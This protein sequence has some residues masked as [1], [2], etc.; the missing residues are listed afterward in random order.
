VLLLHVLP[1]KARAGD[2]AQSAEAA[3]LAYLDTVVAYFHAAGISA[4]S[5]VRY[6]PAPATIVREAR[7]HSADLI[8]LG[9]PVRSALLRAVLGSVADTVIRTAPCPVLLVQPS[10]EAGTGTPLRSFAQSAARAGALTRHPPRRQTVEV[11]RIIG[12]VGRVHELGADFRPPRRVRR[13]SDDQRLARVRSAM[14]RGQALPPVELYQL[15]F[16]Y[17]VLDGH[18]RVAAARLLGQLALDANVVGF[19]PAMTAAAPTDA[20]SMGCAGPADGNSHHAHGH[21]LPATCTD[22]G[23]VRRQRQD[24]DHAQRPDRPALPAHRRH[25]QHV[26]HPR[27]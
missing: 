1:V 19:V 10:L 17:Y 18:H 3:A 13:E 7:E 21:D 26:V 4:T 11:A 5:L 8:I 20:T 2:G 23:T 14:Q 12:S 16:G 22:H 25:A 27:G 9:A 15:G 24:R 6:G